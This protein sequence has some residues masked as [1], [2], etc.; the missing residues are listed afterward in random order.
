MLAMAYQRVH[1]GRSPDHDT[2]QAQVY[3]DN[4][5]AEP[6]VRSPAAGGVSTYEPFGEDKY[7]I[8]THA[9]RK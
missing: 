9:V 6:V 4:E 5:V 2:H 7:D 3:N 1:Q 8:R